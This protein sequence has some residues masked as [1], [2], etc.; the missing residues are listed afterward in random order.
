MCIVIIKIIIIII[1]FYLLHLT[2]KTFLFCASSI[3]FQIL[4]IFFC[5]I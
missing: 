2:F 3:T 1:A 5:G 4:L